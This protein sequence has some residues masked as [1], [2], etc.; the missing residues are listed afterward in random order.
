MNKLMSL[1]V[2]HIYHHCSP[3]PTELA[4]FAK[5]PENRVMYKA[6]VMHFGMGIIGSVVCFFG[7]TW[8][9]GNSGHGEDVCM[10]GF[11]I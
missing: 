6:T 5:F 4:R 1:C 10:I 7:G 2:P 3:S 8:G 11:V 9:L